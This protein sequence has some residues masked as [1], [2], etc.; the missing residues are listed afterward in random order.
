MKFFEA[1]PTRVKAFTD[2]L[3]QAYEAQER[4]ARGLKPIDSLDV[5]SVYL[6]DG[7]V[8]SRVLPKTEAITTG[9]ILP[10][11]SADNALAAAPVDKFVQAQGKAGVVDLS[12]AK[13]V[14]L[15][16]PK[17]VVTP[18]S[19]GEEPSAAAAVEVAPGTLA[20]AWL[21]VKGWFG[22]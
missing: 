12:T 10:I 18:S 8:V 15:L 2:T 20:S 4:L 3:W 21:T 1:D 13:P 14:E 9:Y 7:R 19:D 6:P 16:D 5:Q 17:L 22:A 11:I